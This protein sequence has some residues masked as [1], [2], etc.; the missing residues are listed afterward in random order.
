MGEDQSPFIPC[1]SHTSH[2]NGTD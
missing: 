1:S 2:E